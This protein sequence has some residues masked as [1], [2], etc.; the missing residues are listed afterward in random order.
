MG[1]TVILLG[2]P[3]VGKSTVLHRLKSSNVHFRQFSVRLFT[4]QLLQGDSELGR[5]LRE[6]NIVRPKAFMPDSVVEQIFA[7]FLKSLDAGDFLVIEGFPINHVQFHGMKRQLDRAGRQLDRVIVLDDE[8]DSILARIALRRVCPACEL[9][10]GAGLPVPAV[11]VRCPYCG[12]PLARRA[13]DDEALF[14]QRCE[15]FRQQLSFLSELLPPE[16]IMMIDVG[17]QNA[18]EVIQNWRNN[19]GG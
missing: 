1:N 9:K 13:E 18:T 11:A 8:P 7:E 10:N 12:G 19:N 15:L 3:G 4:M 2:M 16:K 14:G 5:Y 17:K 6:N